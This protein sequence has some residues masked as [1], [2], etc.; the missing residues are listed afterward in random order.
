MCEFEKVDRARLQRI[1]QQLAWLPTIQFWAAPTPRWRAL[2]ILRG[3][4]FRSGRWEVLK[5]D[6]AIKYC[7]DSG[8]TTSEV[9]EI[10]T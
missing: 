6:R 2:L 5:D 9:R 3:E 1:E 4:T 10:L 7:P 8:S